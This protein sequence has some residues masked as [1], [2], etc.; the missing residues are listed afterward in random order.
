MIRWF[1]NIYHRELF[2]PGLIGIF[3][4]PFFF[5]R[6]RLYQTIA[7]FSD[8]LYG[9]M[10]DFGCGEMPYRHLFKVNKYIGLDII[11]SGHNLQKMETIDLFYDGGKI[12]IDDASIDCILSSQVFEHINN[13][14]EVLNEL[15]RL[16][17]PGGKLLISVPFLWEEHEEPFDYFRYSSFGI[18]EM[19]EKHN[20]DI[21]N[22][23]KCTTSIEACFQIFVAY[24]YSC[25]PNNRYLKFIFTIVII[26]P[27]NIFG[28]ICSCFFPYSDSLYLNI[29]IL[30]I[31][32][33]N[34]I[35]NQQ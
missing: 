22:K 26:G 35:T 29:V 17:K 11:R 28:L 16:L 31:K 13:L 5:A 15:N 27:I 21:Q 25:F 4:N 24:L 30:S 18:E 12:P 10:L 20:F 34:I 33:K 9:N 19:L 14:N 32:S 1:K 3:V 2:K 23:R 8:N 7:H 6:R